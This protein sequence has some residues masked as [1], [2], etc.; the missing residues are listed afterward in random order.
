MSDTAAGTSRPSLTLEGHPSQ[1][2]EKLRRGKFVVC[3]E[4]DPPRGINPRRALEGAALLQQAG[5][6]AVN[7]G[8]SPMA[9]ARMSPI[10]MG[11]LIQQQLGLE[12]IVHFTTRD[13]NL[14]GIHSDLLGAY[15][16]GI[17]NVLCSRGDPPAV[18]GYADAI[19]VW[20]V[21]SSGLVRILKLLNEGKDWSEKG[22]GRPT[23][24]F[25]GASASP[26][27]DSLE[28]ELKLIKRKLEAGAQ[29]FMTQAAYD[30]ATLERFLARVKPLQVP[31]LIGLMPLQNVRHAEYLHREVPGVVI[32]E[33]VRDRMRRAGDN[34]VREGL[35]MARDLVAL[36]REWASGVYLIPSFSRYEGV[37]EL[38]AAVRE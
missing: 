7:V 1:L 29:F 13:R 22:I 24:F 8:D 27:A 20:D 9:R 30:P 23:D 32:P 16:Q 33:E 12:A 31:F 4:V 35:A 28:R 15:V 10:A 26:T 21:N 17:R 11:V 34:G 3:V 36:C 5:A 18:G 14:I 25:I 38:V 37:A 2:G 19:G 6:D